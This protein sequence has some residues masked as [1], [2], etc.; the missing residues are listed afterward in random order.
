[1]RQRG[2]LGV[3]DI[4]QQAAGGAQAAGG[5]FHAEANQIAGA[6]L[7]VK[8]LARGVDFELP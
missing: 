7:Q 5:V 6:E 4:L 3:F 1:M 8:L 2:T